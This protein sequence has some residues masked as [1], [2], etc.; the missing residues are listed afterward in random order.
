MN[1][2]GSEVDRSHLSLLQSGGRSTVSSE[3]RRTVR[4]D[5]EL[6]RKLCRT[7]HLEDQT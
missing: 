3:L 1:R 6:F 5:V 2:D 4:S 7:D